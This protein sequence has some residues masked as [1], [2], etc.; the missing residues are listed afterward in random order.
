MILRVYSGS[1][2]ARWYEYRYG[3]WLSIW[4]KVL[5]FVSI[6]FVHDAVLLHSRY[7]GESK[8]LSKFGFTRLQGTRVQK[9]AQSSA[10]SKPQFSLVPN[11]DAR[12]D[13]ESSS[14]N[15]GP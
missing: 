14:S 8:A 9:K 10:T 3:C 12:E 4:P 1:C 15:L 7:F 2:K 5:N 6:A 11:P 13:L